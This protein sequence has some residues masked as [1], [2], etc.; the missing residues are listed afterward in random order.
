[1]HTLRPLRSL[2]FLVRVLKEREVF[3]FE[4]V[5]VWNQNGSPHAKRGWVLMASS[6]MNSE[7]EASPHGSWCWCRK[8]GE[9]RR[10]GGDAEHL[11]ALLQPLLDSPAPRPHVFLHHQEVFE[12]TAIRTEGGS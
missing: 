11:L 5:R 4:V 1:M 8:S 7:C 3:V 6:G 10:E 9:P 2:I 12:L